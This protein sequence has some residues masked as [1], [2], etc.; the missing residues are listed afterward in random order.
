MNTAK[1]AALRVDF[2]SDIMC[3]WCVIGYLQLTQAAAKVEVALD[4][5]WHPFELNPKMPEGG[6]N[7]LE[8]V[9]KKY[10]TTPEESEKARKRL[11][12]TAHDL[13]FTFVFSD[14]SRMVNSFLAH[15]LVEWADG[16]QAQHKIKIALFKAHFSDRRD[17]SDINILTAIAGEAGLDPTAARA[18][19]G[20]GGLGNNVRMM[21]QFWTEHGIQGAPAMI[22]ASEHILIG[23]RGVAAY[24][25]L[26]KKLTRTA[27]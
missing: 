1:H 3:P 12:K 22:F 7:L 19:L 8:H 18:A 6:Q 15:Q 26:L 5:H 23:A 14:D 20:S 25:A 13:G 24:A 9:S 27:A 10:G 16:F 4:I 17:V 2:V 11:V 21:E